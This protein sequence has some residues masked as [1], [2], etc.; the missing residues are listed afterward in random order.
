L[1]PSPE[2]QPPFTLT[3]GILN[4][5][6][7]VAEM[8]GKLSAENPSADDLRLRKANRIKTIQGSLAIEGNTLSEEQITAILAGKRVLAPPREILEAQ[9]AFAA[10]ERLENW[11]PVAEADLLEAH[12]LL[13][14]G[15]LDSAGKFRAGGVGVMKGEEV[16]HMAPPASQVPQLVGNLLNWLAE[17]DHH[18]LISSSIFHYEFEFIH[19]FADGNGRVGRLWQSLILMGWKPAFAGIPVESL[20]FRNQA[21]YYQAIQA[22]TAQ[23][24][25]APFVEFMISRIA[26]AIGAPTPQATPQATPQVNAL[27]LA[28]NGQMGREELQADLGL[29]D[30]KSFRERYLTPAVEMGLVEMTQPDKPNSPNQRYLLTPQGRKYRIRLDPELA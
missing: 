13:M 22:S 14:E 29:A 20:V 28:F 21:D 6:A 8:V 24:D 18:P 1:S 15:L 27:I 7:E 23:A 25:C 10:Y 30:R 2:Y 11:K 4:Q 26:D 9:N 17:T 5:V 12:R 16:I 19:P 3:P